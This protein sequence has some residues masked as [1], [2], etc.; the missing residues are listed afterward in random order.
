MKV[1]VITVVLNGVETIEDCIK[2]VI[3]Q[4]Y[5]HIEHII[6]DGRSKDGTVDIIEKYRDGFAY[7]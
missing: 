2:S 3:E 6:I 4:T 1:S 7:S 5:P